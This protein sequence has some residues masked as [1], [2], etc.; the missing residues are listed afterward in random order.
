MSGELDH[1]SKEGTETKSEVCWEQQTQRGDNTASTRKWK[2][3]G[4][5][6]L[7]VTNFIYKEKKKKDSIHKK[8]Y[9]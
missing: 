8:T 2:D 5:L 1:S 3:N 4:S 6:G 7:K 9:L